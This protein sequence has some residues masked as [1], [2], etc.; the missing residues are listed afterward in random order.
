MFKTKQFLY[1]Q[2]AICLFNYLL[3]PVQVYSHIKSSARLISLSNVCLP[4]QNLGS[5]RNC[6][7]ENYSWLDW[8]DLSILITCGTTENKNSLITHWVRQKLRWSYWSPLRF[9]TLF[10][11]A[12]NPPLRISLRPSS[13][14][15]QYLEKLRLRLLKRK[16]N[17]WTPP[18]LVINVQYNFFLFLWNF[19]QVIQSQ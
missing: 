4:H 5:T 14:S 11:K 19:F 18:H 6:T 13:N 2:C 10:L 16:W 8:S 3:K 17:S 1:K 7:Y 9:A 12:K 15:L